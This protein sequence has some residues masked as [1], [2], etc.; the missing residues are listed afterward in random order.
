[1]H[2]KTS[3]INITIQAKAT[4]G[5]GK[6]QADSGTSEFHRTVLTWLH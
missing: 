2:K 3:N 1:M 4:A 6:P 5:V